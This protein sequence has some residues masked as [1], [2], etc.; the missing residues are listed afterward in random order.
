[1]N[2][3]NSVLIEGTVMSEPI[4]RVTKKGGSICSFAI[5][6]KRCNKNGGEF[7][8]E[9]SCF[10]VEACSRLAE[11]IKPLCRKNCG[12]RV[13][14]RLHQIRWIDHNGQNCSRVII[15]ADYAEFSPSFKREDGQPLI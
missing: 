7:E 5:V 10:E 3:L 1:M 14:G 12:I 6:S 15:K 11:A 8:K 4:Y 13:V 2:N 9:V